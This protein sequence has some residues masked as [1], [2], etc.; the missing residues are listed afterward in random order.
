MEIKKDPFDKQKEKLKK[1]KTKRNLPNFVIKPKNIKIKRKVVSNKVGSSNIPDYNSLSKND[2]L[3]IL[4]EFEKG[5][6]KLNKVYNAGINI[7]E[8]KLKS[9]EEQHIKYHSWKMEACIE[10]D[11]RQM[12][13]Y[14]YSGLGAIELTGR[15]FGFDVGGLTESQK[16]HQKTYDN[17]FIL[18]LRKIIQKTLQNLI[19]WQI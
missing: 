5:F 6:R 11:T 7:E 9:L 4:E 14:F 13:I 12:R 15:F 3:Y 1:V 8:M 10:H 2:Q 17:A 18:S 16:K 19:Q